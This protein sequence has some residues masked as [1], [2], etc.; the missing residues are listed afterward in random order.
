MKN[1]RQEPLGWNAGRLRLHGLRL[2]RNDEMIEGGP[3]HVSEAKWP[4]SVLDG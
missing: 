1:C 4:Y 3:A 2:S